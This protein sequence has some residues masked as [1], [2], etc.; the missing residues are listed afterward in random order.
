[1]ACIAV[2]VEFQLQR[3]DAAAIDHHRAER[4]SSGRADP[5]L[6]QP[7]HVVGRLQDHRHAVVNGR[8]QV[9]RLACGDGKGRFAE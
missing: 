7:A 9:V 6:D 5:A 1:M 8:H 3:I 2:G 4:A